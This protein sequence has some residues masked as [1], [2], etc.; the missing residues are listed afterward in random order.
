MKHKEETIKTQSKWTKDDLDCAFVNDDEEKSDNE[1][2]FE[3]EDSEYV[4]DDNFHDNVKN[5]FKNHSI[6]NNNDE[7]KIFSDTFYQIKNNDETLFNKLVEKFN[8]KEKKILNDL[9]FVRNVKVEYKG[10]ELDVPRRTL[11]IKR[12]VH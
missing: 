10:K 1:Y 2:D 3:D 8:K 11:K 7:F 9:L 12:T 4:F 5:C 6:I